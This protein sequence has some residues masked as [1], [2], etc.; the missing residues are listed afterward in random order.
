MNLSIEHA[1][2]TNFFSHIY[3]LPLSICFQNKKEKIV[4]RLAENFIKSGTIRVS[5]WFLSQTKEK[6]SLPPF[7][8]YDIDKN[9]IF[10]DGKIAPLDWKIMPYSE[11]GL[12]RG[13]HQNPDPPMS[14]EQERKYKNT[15]DELYFSKAHIRKKE[16]WIFDEFY[17]V[18]KIKTPY[19]SSESKLKWNLWKKYFIYTN[20]NISGELLFSQKFPRYIVTNPVLELFLQ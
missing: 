13:I 3:T 15:I 10:I 19:P 20:K 1:L 18:N 4:V 7:I 12:S 14:Y 6:E 16:K 8:D 11:R 17:K 9:E 2:R 5:H